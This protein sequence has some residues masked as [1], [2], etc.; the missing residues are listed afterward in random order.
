MGPE[1][2]GLDAGAEVSP[3][4]CFREGLTWPLN[5]LALARVVKVCADHVHLVTWPRRGAESKFEPDKMRVVLVDRRGWEK[6]TRG[7]EPIRILRMFVVVSDEGGE[8]H[9][10]PVESIRSIERIP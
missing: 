1:A 4:L 5:R 6:L 2:A 8:E 9:A 7:V 3:E 10:F